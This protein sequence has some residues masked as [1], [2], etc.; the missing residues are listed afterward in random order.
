MQDKP[1]YFSKLNL[2]SGLC[3]TCEIFGVDILV[4]AN[5]R[6]SDDRQFQN[7]SVTSEKWVNILEVRLRGRYI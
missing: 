7:L 5:S 2:V 6:I 3:R 1:R 4:L